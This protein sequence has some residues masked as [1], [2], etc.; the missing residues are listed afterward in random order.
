MK[1]EKKK[2]KYNKE[3]SKEDILLQI[4]ISGNEKKKSWKQRNQRKEKSQGR[5]DNFFIQWFLVFHLAFQPD[6]KRS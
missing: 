1:T 6:L 3:K 5:A 2:E 4:R